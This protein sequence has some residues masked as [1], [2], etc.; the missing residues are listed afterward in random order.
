MHAAEHSMCSPGGERGVLNPENSREVNR[1]KGEQRDTGFNGNREAKTWNLQW[2]MEPSM[3]RAQGDI[4]GGAQRTWK[5]GKSK[6][7]YIR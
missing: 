7:Y 1:K 3:G 4:H 5:P 2:A 6:T